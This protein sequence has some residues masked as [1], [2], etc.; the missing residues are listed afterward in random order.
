[1]TYLGLKDVFFVKKM[2][3]RQK[4][5]TFA[6]TSLRWNYWIF[7]RFC[8]RVC[9]SRL[10]HPRYWPNGHWES[11]GTD[12]TMGVTKK[13]FLTFLYSGTP[14]WMKCQIFNSQKV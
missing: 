5:K 3:K 6:R 12:G 8:P 4:R 7:G 14:I 9:S 1:M 2:A 11:R 10:S 13:S